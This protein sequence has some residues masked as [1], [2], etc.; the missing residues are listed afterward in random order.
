MIAFG[1][2]DVVHSSPIRHVWLD[3]IIAYGRTF[4]FIQNITIMSRSNVNFK[5]NFEVIIIFKD[6]KLLYQPI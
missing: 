6:P 5:E 3:G 2:L 1:C 4:S